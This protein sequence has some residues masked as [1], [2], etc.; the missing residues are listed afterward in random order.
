MSRI[1]D[2]T[3]KERI[4]KKLGCSIEEYFKKR[5]ELFE[6]LKGPEGEVFE[7]E[8]YNPLV[9]LETEELDFLSDY[10]LTMKIA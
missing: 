7:G 10:V 1:G 8:V 6:S 5:D 9:E 2:D 4:E 3:M